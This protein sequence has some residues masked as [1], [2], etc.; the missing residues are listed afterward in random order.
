LDQQLMHLQTVVGRLANRLQRRLLAKQNRSWEFDLEEGMLDAARLPR[1]V[2][3][4]EMPLSYKR[5]RDTEFRDTV[6]TLLIDNSGSMRGRPITVAAMRRRHPGSHAGALRRQVE[7]LG[8]T[9]RMWKGGQSRERW[10]AAG[11]PANPGRLNDC[12]I[13]STNPPTPLAPGPQEPGADA[14]RGHLEGEHRRRG[15]ALGP[16]PADGPHRAA[17]H[18]D[19]DRRRRAGG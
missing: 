12:A 6:V 17:P 9:T 8:F 10:I 3:N 1:V 4:P 11:K 14:A 16:S 7:V 13:S 18:P 15:P 2:V 5:E 19:G